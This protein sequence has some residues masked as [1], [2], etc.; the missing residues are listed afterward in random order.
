[1]AAAIAL[2]LL[3]LGQAEERPTAAHPHGLPFES[4]L[5][6]SPAAYDFF[7]PSVR[8]R[9]A[10]GV[11][12]AP[13]LAPRGQRQQQQLRE[14]AVRGATASVARADQEEG[15]VAPVRTV[16]HRTVA[17]VFVGAAA[18]ALVAVGVA[19]AVGAFG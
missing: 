18:A 3:P 1:M 14:S 5:A 17:G 8:A 7:H 12:P 2:L 11:A 4:P 19:Y 6:L 9:R 15:S 16:R 13:A 10:H